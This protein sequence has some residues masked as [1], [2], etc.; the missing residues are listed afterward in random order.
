MAIRLALLQLVAFLFAQPGSAQLAGTDREEAKKMV[1][2]TVY[3][4][5]DA[6]CKYGSGGFGLSV[7]PLV[8]VSPAEYKTEG[9]ETIPQKGRKRE[10]VYWGFAPNDPIRYI[11]L[12]FN[13][14]SI[15]VWG[16]GL[17]PKDNE[18]MVR[19]VGIKSIDDFRKAFDLALSRVPL[20]D[21]HPDWP[22]EI[23]KAI[24]D[25]RVVEGMTKRQ[26]FCV[27][28]TPVNIQIS[29]DGGAEVETWFPRQE[30]G[31]VVTFRKLK[32]S[33]TGYPALLKFVDGR[34]TGIEA[35]RQS[36]QLK[37]DK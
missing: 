11:K 18:V 20:Q 32:S 3:L 6:P 37:L 15:D 25:R 24:A 33:A 12:S 27:V 4:R 26:A 8:R 35:T 34:L 29:K 9:S 14:D 2:G 28:G 10:S 21:E 17:P 5:I 19:F 31:T 30:N 16:E 22:A 23:R 7:E 13:G 1:S 36:D